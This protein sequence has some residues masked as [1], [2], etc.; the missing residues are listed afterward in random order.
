MVQQII[1][2]FDQL[3]KVLDTFNKE[4]FYDYQRGNWMFYPHKGNVR[5]AA[6]I[7]ASLE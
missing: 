4:N 5:V 7:V 1:K 2:E 6:E 3:F